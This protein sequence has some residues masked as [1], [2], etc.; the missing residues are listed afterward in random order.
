MIIIKQKYKYSIILGLLL[1]I[2]G[3]FINSPM[4]MDEALSAILII[5]GL[6]LFVSGCW[7][8]AQEKGLSRAWGLLGLLSFFG[9]LILLLLPNHKK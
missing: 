9:L 3:I 5:S 4:G 2:I 8:Y 7:S 6:A 1:Q